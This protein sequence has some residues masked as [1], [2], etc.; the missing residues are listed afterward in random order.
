MLRGGRGLCPACGR[1]RLLQN[2]LKPIPRCA[3]CDENLEPYQTA[4]FAAYIV[5]FFVGLVATPF[6]F[7][8]SVSGDTG[9]WKIGAVM[10]GATLLALA[11]L[12]LAKGAII[13][14]LW[15]LDIKS[16]V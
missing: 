12:P 4:D 5:M 8:V 13:G 16:N 6:V 10:V 3:S 2:Y 11:L 15:A 14:L 1:G 7:A 9:P